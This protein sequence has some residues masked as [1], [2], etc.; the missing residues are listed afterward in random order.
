MKQIRKDKSDKVSKRAMGVLFLLVASELIGFGLIIPILPQIASKFQSNGFLMAVLLA[1]YSFCQ[2]IASPILGSWSDRYGRKPVLVISKIGSVISYLILSV[3]FS[4]YLILI[5]RIIDG[6]T[7]GN[8]AVARA[9]ISD[10]TNEENRSKGM[11]CDRDCIC[12]WIYIGS[13]IGSICFHIESTH[14]LAAIVAGTCSLISTLITIFFLEESVSKHQEKEHLLKSFT[15]QIKIPG[16]IPLFLSQAIFM[17]I[18]SGF[19]TSFSVFNLQEYNLNEAQNSMI[20]LYSGLLSLIIQ[21][22]LMRKGFNNIQLITGCGIAFNAIGLF[23]IALS[24]T[25]TQLLISLIVMSAGIA[26]VHVHLPSMVSIKSKGMGK[27]QA[28][29]TYESI[30]SISRI[31]GPF[32]IY[33]VFV[34]DIQSAYFIYAVI[35]V[36]TSILFLSKRSLST[37][38]T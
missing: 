24:S 36:F 32:V 3:S 34:E 25:I 15:Q 2:A 38:T 19:E 22:S 14:R 31:I 35:L 1:A 23:L 11:G 18:F 29:G 4:Y 12:I 8:I 10:I 9:Y 26:I 7:G 33:S 13:A 37:P 27:G 17:T 6:F 30:G 16:M 28:M 21:G 5:S 20:F